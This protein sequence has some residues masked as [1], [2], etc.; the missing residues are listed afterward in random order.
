M[1]VCTGKRIFNNESGYD[2]ICRCRPNISSR[3]RQYRGCISREDIS[4]LSLG[5]Q[6]GAPSL[7]EKKRRKER[8]KEKEKE[9][10]VK[11]QEKKEKQKESKR[12]KGRKKEREKERR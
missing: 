3:N 6:S 12:E 4:N 10:K 5:S 11:V 9:K 8:A 1:R 7:Q 2:R